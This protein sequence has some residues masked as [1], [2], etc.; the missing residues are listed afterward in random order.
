[1]CSRKLKWVS[2]SVTSSF[3]KKVREKAILCS[4]WLHTHFKGESCN[5]EIREKAP[6]EE[7][8]QASQERG[9]SFLSQINCGGFMK[10]LQSADSPGLPSRIV[11]ADPVWGH[12][13]NRYM[14]TEVKP[15]PL[16]TPCTLLHGATSTERKNIST[17]IY[18]HTFNLHSPGTKVLES[19]VSWGSSCLLP[20]PGLDVGLAPW[21]RA[22]AWL[23]LP[24]GATW[25]S[26]ETLKEITPSPRR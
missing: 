3:Q 25:S 18:T 19:A 20:G 10:N 21:S 1:M 6:C 24:E 16:T 5:V 9:S 22:W 17:A 23:R 4:P 26:E 2:V 7:T 12:L 14:G 11:Q 13:V 8:P 15:C